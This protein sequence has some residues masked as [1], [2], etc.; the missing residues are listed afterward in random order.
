MKSMELLRGYEPAAMIHR[1]SPTPLLMTVAE[2]DVLTPTDLALEAYG[3]A[4]EPKE[5]NL[6]R[7]AG[8]F[9]GYSGAWFGRN[10]GKQTEFLGKW[11]CGESVS[12]V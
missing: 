1:I 4:R 2:R 8:H 9:D 11:L 12:D 10:A 7:G 3:R 5:L 6:L